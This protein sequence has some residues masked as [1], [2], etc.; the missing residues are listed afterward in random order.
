MPKFYGPVGYIETVKDE[1]SPDVWVEKPVERFYK[2]DL[3]KNFRNLTKSSE[4]ELNDD[5]T[6]SNQISITAN[7][8]ALSHMA[9]MRYVKWMGTAWKVTGVDA[10][11]YPRLILSIGGVY[12]GETAE[13]S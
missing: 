10:S 8:Y 4:G 3:M 11:N 7:P 1:N 2:G 12:N 5:V 6:L 9:D 13:Q